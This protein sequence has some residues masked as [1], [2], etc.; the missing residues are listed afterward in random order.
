MAET[1]RLDE[2]IAELG[3]SAETFQILRQDLEARAAEAER[4]EVELLADLR[5]RASIVAERREADGKRLLAL[6]DGLAAVCSVVK[7]EAETD[8][9]ARSLGRDAALAGVSLAE[10]GEFDLAPRYRTSPGWGG[11]DGGLVGV[12]RVPGIAPADA[13]EAP[14]WLYAPPAAA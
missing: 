3:L 10:I 14:E 2:E 7:R 8:G 12:L 13:A 9:L 1:A 11:R 6:A 5:R 4:R